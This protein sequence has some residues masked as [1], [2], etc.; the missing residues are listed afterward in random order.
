MGL[1]EST[2]YQT[3]QVTRNGVAKAV[4]AGASD[5]FVFVIVLHGLD[6]SSMKSSNLI[7][8]RTVSI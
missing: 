7:G 4:V 5:F 3:V 6:H 8:Y 1:L 2:V